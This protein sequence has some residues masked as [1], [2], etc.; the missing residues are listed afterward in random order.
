MELTEAIIDRPGPVRGK[1]DASGVP[2]RSGRGR[3]SLL[4]IGAAIGLAACSTA[5]PEFTPPA[6]QSPTQW[7]ERHGGASELAAPAGNARVGS[8]E[9]GSRNAVATLSWADFADPVLN[10]LIDRARSNNQDLRV[11]LLRVQQSRMQQTMVSAQRGV[12]IDANGAADRERQSRDGSASRL[13]NAIGGPGTQPLLDA[14][15]QPFSLYQAGFDASWEFDLWGRLARSEEVAQAS[16]QAAEAQM[17]QMQL[18]IDGELARAYFNLRSAQRQQRLLAA[19]MVLATESQRLLLARQNHGLSDAS[20]T[21]KQVALI[22]SLKA[23]QPGVLALQAQALNQITLLCGLPAG[24]LN[25]RL[26]DRSAR[27]SEANVEPAAALRGSSQGQPDGSWNWIAA[28][29]PDLLLGLP[30]DL[31]RQ[32]PDI[33]A[34]EAR[35]HAATAAIGVSV[36]ELYPSIILGARFGVESLTSAGLT[37]WTS[38]QW[39]IGPA[40]NVPVFDHG[41]RRAT[42]ELRRLEQQEALVAWQQAVL[43]AWHEV[44]DAISTYQAEVAVQVSLTERLKTLDAELLL[45]RGRFEQG[46]TAQLPVLEARSNRVA[47]RRE[48][49]DNLARR[50]VAL[51]ALVKALGTERNGISGK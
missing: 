35:A 8:G 29:L 22:E 33:V 36:A 17:R 27:I 44:D 50:Q 40:F 4:I 6:V 11:A 37:Q 10:E 42:V 24:D 1:F 45:A 32:R 18:S 41:R 14:L 3:P 46:L 20:A 15:S 5:G 7:D 19:S 12:Q 49:S 26:A 21:L 48:L 28:P 51:V 31:I 34:A 16:T 47:A 9:A 25:E 30:G 13:V 43:K 39:S 2:P 23:Q 38:R